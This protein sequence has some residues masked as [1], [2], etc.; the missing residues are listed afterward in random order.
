MP[1]VQAAVQ[2]LS[3]LQGYVKRMVSFSSAGAYTDRWDI[4]VSQK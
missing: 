4:S 1:V 3:D 2:W